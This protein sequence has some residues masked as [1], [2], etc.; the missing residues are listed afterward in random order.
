M[1]NKNNRDIMKK[2]NTPRAISLSLNTNF[3]DSE[4]VRR[5]VGQG[6]ANALV[7]FLALQTVIR[8]AGYC[9][10]VDDA[11]IGRL[12][13]MTGRDARSLRADIAVLVEAGFFDAGIYSAQSV[14]TTRRLQSAY[15]RRKDAQPIPERLQCRRTK[16]SAKSETIEIKPIPMSRAERRRLERDRRR[17]AERAANRRVIPQNAI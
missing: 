16:A 13:A 8:K 5:L 6:N 10:S 1:Y 4:P 9:V 2:S 7:T 14:L 12:A 17:R 15:R 11:L 3:M